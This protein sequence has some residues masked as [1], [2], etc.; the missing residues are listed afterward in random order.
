MKLHAASILKIQLSVADDINIMNKRCF[1]T[2]L[3]KV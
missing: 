2:L 1:I 3:L